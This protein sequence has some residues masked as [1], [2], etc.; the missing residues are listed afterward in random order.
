MR[1]PARGGFS[2]VEAL[3]VLSIT[4]VLLILL[5]S[6]STGGVRAGFHVAAR[7]DVVQERLVGTEALRVLLRAVRLPERGRSTTPFVGDGDGFT[8]AVTPG[9]PTP[10]GSGGPSALAMR[11]DRTGGRTR[12]ICARP[13]GKATVL[14]DLGASPATFSYA[15]AGRPW[16]DRLAS[17]LP[18]ERPGAAPIPA[19]ARPRL[20]LR[21]SAADGPEVLEEADTPPSPPRSAGA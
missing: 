15:L 18:P 19:V 17:V 7:A 11:L 3:I 21:L 20:W 6:V 4:S 1:A 16:S 12:L 10:C 9:R 5:F 8:A 2:L 13:D 14:L